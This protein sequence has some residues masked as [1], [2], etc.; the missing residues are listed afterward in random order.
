MLEDGGVVL[1]RL[2]GLPV[3]PQER[4]NRRHLSPLRRIVSPR[5][6]VEWRGRISTGA[7]AGG[8]GLGAG[9][10]GLGIGAISAAGAIRSACAT[11]ESAE[12]AEPYFSI[13]WKKALRAP[14]VSAGG[15]AVSP[16]P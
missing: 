2:L 15:A 5:M 1:H 12:L 16:A 11:A 7:G 4:R 10:G 13:L 14:L 3:E 6:L 8:W 9:C